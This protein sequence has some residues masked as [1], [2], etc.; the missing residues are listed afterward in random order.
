[1]GS[2]CSQEPLNKMQ[3]GDKSRH[4]PP[5]GKAVPVPVRGHGGGT[6]LPAPQ[7][8]QNG[9][10]EGC[11]VAGMLGYRDMRMCCLPGA[12]ASSPFQVSPLGAAASPCQ[13]VRQH[14]SPPALGCGVRDKAFPEAACWC[15]DRLGDK[16]VPPPA[17]RVSPNL[18]P[19]AR[20]GRL[21]GSG[22]SMWTPW[23]WSRNRLRPNTS[24]ML[25]GS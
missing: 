2:L 13:G 6:S 5:R 21:P 16:R 20:P 4:A 8:G 3:E 19:G 10:A 12:K 25:G 7:L 9:E 17:P 23:G 14:H 15:T 1:M 22:G 24:A 11:G 18:H